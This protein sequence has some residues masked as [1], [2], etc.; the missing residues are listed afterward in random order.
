MAFDPYKVLTT[1]RGVVRLFTTDLLPEGDA[2]ITSAN[3]HK[4][5]GEEIELDPSKVEVFPPSVIQPVG[6]STYLN[7]GHGIPEADLEGT[8]AA[9]DAMTGLVIVIPT[10]AFM[11]RDVTLDPRAGIRFVG[12]FHEPRAEHPKAMADTDMADGVLS[13][14]GGASGDPFIR[15]RRGW[16][17]AL[18]AL[19]AAAALV[20]FAVF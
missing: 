1:E 16:M 20:L 4:L 7:E 10:T 19:L 13:P 5:L 6:M 15:H 11:G 8:A 2:A 3:V 9:L 14:R 17:L 12:A 18:A